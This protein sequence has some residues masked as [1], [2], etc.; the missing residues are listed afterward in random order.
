[1]KVPVDVYL[2][3]R[4]AGEPTPGREPVA[5]LFRADDAARM[6]AALGA[7]EERNGPPHGIAR[8]TYH[9]STVAFIPAADRCGPE[10]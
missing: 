7:D 9:V 4:V 3:W 6:A 2:V 10:V 8:A 1:M 5:V